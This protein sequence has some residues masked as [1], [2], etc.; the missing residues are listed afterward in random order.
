MIFLMHAC[1]IHVSS[2]SS[3][4]KKLYKR[5]IGDSFPIRMN[6]TEILERLTKAVVDGD[7]EAAK[8]AAETMDM[9]YEAMGMKF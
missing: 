4:R 7:E 3:G 1:I 5:F 8:K 9:V 6:K 2:F